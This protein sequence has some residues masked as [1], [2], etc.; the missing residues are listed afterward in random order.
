[1]YGHR[2]V[3]VGSYLAEVAHVRLG[4][5]APRAFK[6]TGG[7]EGCWCRESANGAGGQL[8]TIVLGAGPYRG[9]SEGRGVVSGLS[10]S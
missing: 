3:A 7:G 8:D 10:G 2:G 6:D 1:M 9:R 5:A 4:E